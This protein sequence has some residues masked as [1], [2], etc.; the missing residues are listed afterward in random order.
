MAAIVPE[1]VTADADAVV[2]GDNCELATLGASS[3]PPIS[4]VA[5]CLPGTN[6]KLAVLFMTTDDQ[7]NIHPFAWMG[8]S[9]SAVKQLGQPTNPVLATLESC[10]PCGSHEECEVRSVLLSEESDPDPFEEPAPPLDAIS[11]V[12]ATIDIG[13]VVDA[14]VTGEKCMA[15]MA[16]ELAQHLSK[17]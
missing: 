12:C 15:I 4:L 1:V 2:C 9:S 14:H 13:E 6:N 11:S 5:S 16:C 7:G 8:S 10:V 17:Q 3:V